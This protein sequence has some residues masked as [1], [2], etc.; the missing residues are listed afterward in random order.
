MALKAGKKDIEKL[1]TVLEGDYGDVTEAATA[2]LTA[3]WDIYE[4]KAKYTV[5]S[6]LRFS[7]QAGTIDPLSDEADKIAFGRY[8]TEKQ[9]HDDAMKMAFSTQTNEEFRSWVL[10]VHHG[11]PNDYYKARK[12]ARTEAALALKSPREQELQRRINQT[13]EETTE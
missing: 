4:A 12:Q 9:A 2:A 1:A 5:V 7:A 10:P 6:Q 8:G 13:K 11:T 3:A